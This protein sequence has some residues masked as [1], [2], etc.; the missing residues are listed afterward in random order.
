[1]RRFRCDGLACDEP[2]SYLAVMG[3]VRALRPA[4]GTVRFEGEVPV[5]EVDEHVGLDEALDLVVAAVIEVAQPL[6]ESGD[7]PLPLTDTSVEAVQTWAE[8]GFASGAEPLFGIDMARAG[9]SA[10]KYAAGTRFSTAPNNVMAT[11][12]LTPLLRRLRPT[13][14]SKRAR[15]HLAAFEADV[16]EYIR[17]HVRLL[18]EGAPAEVESREEKMM[19]YSPMAPRS[20][21][22]APDES[23]AWVYPGLELLAAVALPYLPVRGNLPGDDS[24]RWFWWW[25]N[26]APMGWA[27]LLA[28]QRRT[29]LPGVTGFRVKMTS[30]GGGAKNYFQWG[31]VQRRAGSMTEMRRA[32]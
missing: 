8:D 31:Q 5:I 28:A 1:M 6:G 10:G 16:P 14:T 25:L 7:W 4:G 12:M 19:G 2:L 21:A 13:G 20:K 22:L 23:V 18:L 15:E 30:L 9:K 27:S 29:H 26:T 11:G 24:D 32:R 3:L 17:D